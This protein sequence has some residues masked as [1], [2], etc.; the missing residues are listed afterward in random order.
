MNQN[1]PGIDW[2][3]KLVH[4]ADLIIYAQCIK[5]E[6]KLWNATLIACK[7]YEILLPTDDEL[8]EIGVMNIVDGKRKRLFFSKRTDIAI[9]HIWEAEQRIEAETQFFGNDQGRVDKNWYTNPNQV[10][11]LRNRIIHNPFKATDE[12]FQE[13][14]INLIDRLYKLPGIKKTFKET[15]KI[16]EDNADNYEIRRFLERK[17][18][19]IERPRR[20]KSVDRF[21]PAHFENL[22][23]A[24][25]EVFPKLKKNLLSA[26]SNVDFLQK[27]LIQFSVP[28]ST[29]AYVWLTIP[30]KVN[31]PE[32]YKN[33]VKKFAP[34]FS[35]VMTPLEFWSYIELA[36]LSFHF[37]VQYYDFILKDGGFIK[38]IN[39]MSK[40]D[41]N[42]VK[43]STTACLRDVHWYVFEN[44]R[45]DIDGVKDIDVYRQHVSQVLT[46]R[47]QDFRTALKNLQPIT[48]N[49]A[50]PGWV[51]S[52]K[53]ILR[54]KMTVQD[55]VNLTA[56]RLAAMKP[57]VDYFQNSQVLWPN[58]KDYK[59]R[60]EQH[61]RNLLKQ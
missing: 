21:S 8:D 47:H 59:K 30:I 26:L 39:N 20:K 40:Q 7:A 5:N 9:E 14:A 34:A 31:A 15:N 3:G 51:D 19:L 33:S 10:H 6:G 43:S 37:K 23:L 12:K 25:E 11:L 45:L 36:G 61:Y 56:E 49:V 27:D 44:H 29:S 58:H 52:Y 41:H 48:W 18:G 54:R 55:F 13:D 2:N 57:L 22:I 53:D 16:T 50:L 28:D 38:L 1:S 17:Y 46:T 4:A 32:E 24:E 35:I 42:A 60:V